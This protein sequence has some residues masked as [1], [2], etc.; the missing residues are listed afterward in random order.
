[1][2]LSESI[3]GVNATDDI[4]SQETTDHIVPPVLIAYFMAMTDGELA[5]S[6]DSDMAYHCAF[7]LPAVA[8]TLGRANWHVLAKTCDALAANMQYKVRRTLA[9]SLHE[10]ALI[11][12][13]ELT[14]KHL[15][16]IF[17]GLLK[18]LDEVRIGVLRHLAHFLELMGEEQ[19]LKFLPKLKFFLLTDNEWNWRFREELA[20]QLLAAVPLYVP[21]MRNACRRLGQLLH[22]LLFDRVCAVRTAAHEL[23][24]ELVKHTANVD[25]LLCSRLLLKLC[26]DL[27]HSKRYV[28]L[29]IR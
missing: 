9:S 22:D 7:S 21:R 11:L 19:R 8:L 15:L 27:A 20:K 25:W 6:T 18:D 29:F 28:Y 12:G 3:C 17:D 2:E 26:E 14:I 16:P 1:M 4:K 23:T 10:L 5:G 24:C 13:Q